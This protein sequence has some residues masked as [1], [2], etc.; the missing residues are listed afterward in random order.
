VGFLV[1]DDGEV[2]LQVP[3]DIP[4]AIMLQRHTAMELSFV[5]HVV[6]GAA[7]L[8]TASAQLMLGTIVR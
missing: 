8:P 6:I 2:A 4:I 5:T 7:D 3:F 1:A